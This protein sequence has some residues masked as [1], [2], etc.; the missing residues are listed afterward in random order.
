MLSFDPD[1]SVEGKPGTCWMRRFILVPGRYDH[2][3]RQSAGYVK[4]RFAAKRLEIVDGILQ[5]N[6]K[7]REG[8]RTVFQRVRSRGPA[9][10]AAKA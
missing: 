10:E 7:D 2:Q 4:G 8:R 5:R 6:R 9:A 3:H 1:T